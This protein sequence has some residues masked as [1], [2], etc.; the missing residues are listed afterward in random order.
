MLDVEFAQLSDPG[1][2]RD[3]N[4]DYLGHVLPG[5]GRAGPLAW[6]AV[7][8]GGWRGRPRARRSRFPPAVE[9]CWPGSA[10][11][12]EGTCTSRF[13]RAWCRKRPAIST[14]ERCS[15]KPSTQAEP[16][17]ATSRRITWP[18]PSS[19]APCAT[20]APWW[21]TSAIPAA[22]WSATAISTALT[23]DHTVAGEQVRLGILSA[24]EAATAVNQPR[25]EPLPGQRPLRRRRISTVNILPGD[26][27]LLCSDGLHG[28]VSDAEIRADRRRRAPPRTQ[29]AAALVALPTTGRQ[30]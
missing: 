14:R 15:T 23:R 1:R 13:C 8:A 3:H 4:E 19:P 24:G 16:G 26:V 5:D 21:P 2:A 28:S 27:L 22:I 20:T 29:A 17:G 7:R 12:P 25:A 18:P 6:M 30:R 9:T 11:S 10:S